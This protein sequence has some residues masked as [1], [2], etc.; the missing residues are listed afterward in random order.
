MTNETTDKCPK[1]DK[2][3]K[4][5]DSNLFPDSFGVIVH[6]CGSHT[7]SGNFIESK[8]CKARAEMARE[9][10][11]DIA[12]RINDSEYEIGRLIF[13]DE[14]KEGDNLSIVVASFFEHTLNDDGTPHEE[15][16]GWTKFAIEC[17][18]SVQSQVVE[19]LSK[20]LI[21]LLSHGPTQEKSK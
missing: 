12:K 14:I 6:P 17:A 7:D 8:V 18:E 19:R 1:C 11:A 3:G 13:G 16:E 4:H 5:S 15:H 20:R 21:R 10:D 9:S 2:V